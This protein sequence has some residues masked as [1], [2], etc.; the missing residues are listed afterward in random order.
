MQKL[1]SNRK[2]KKNAIQLSARQN[3]NADDLESF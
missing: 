2:N 1:N 3:I